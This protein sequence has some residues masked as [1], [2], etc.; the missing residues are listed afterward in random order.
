MDTNHLFENSLIKNNNDIFGKLFLFQISLNDY[1]V[2]IYQT[3][4]TALAEFYKKMESEDIDF[5]MENINKY[6]NIFIDIFEK[7]FT[8]LFQ[9]HRFGKLFGNMFKNYG[10][11]QNE[12]QQIINKSLKLFNIPSK[13]DI[14][15]LQRELYD[16][17][18]QIYD[19]KKQLGKNEEF[20]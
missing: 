12:N 1:F 14:D 10:E 8:D 19:L 2:I 7:Y 20:L 13:S 15:L 18:K 17:R 5:S 16:L 6:K 9:S 4:L 11:L 3:Y